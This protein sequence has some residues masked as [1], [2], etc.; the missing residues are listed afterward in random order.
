MKI[1]SGINKVFVIDASVAVK[2][3]YQ[4]IESDIAD[5]LLRTLEQEHI[6]VYAPSLLG[7]E[8]GNALGKGKRMIG[9][10]VDKALKTLFSSSIEFV[11]LDE[12]LSEIAVRFMV[13][14]NLTFYDSVYAALAYGLGVPLISANPKDHSKIKD[15]R[16]IELKHI[17]W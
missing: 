9:S 11:E 6:Q 14:Y 1:G 15:I 4:E 8:V 10:A 16:V 5:G 13:R 3:F 7:Y 12:R 2:W 17:T